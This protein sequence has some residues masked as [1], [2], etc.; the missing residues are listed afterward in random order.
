MGRIGTGV[1]GCGG[2]GAVAIALSWCN[3]GYLV[4]SAWVQWGGNWPDHKKYVNFI[5]AGLNGHPLFS[6]DCVV[7]VYIYEKCNLS[8]NKDMI[9]DCLQFSWTTTRSSLYSTQICFACN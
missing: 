7:C 9:S 5:Q 6:Y 2:I 4:R 3:P 8:Y 1:D